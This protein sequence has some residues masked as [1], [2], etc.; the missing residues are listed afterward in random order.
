M[1]M[2]G[3]CLGGALAG[4][5]P[6]LTGSSAARRFPRNS[7]SSRASDARMPTTMAAGRAGADEET[8]CDAVVVGTSLIAMFEALSLAR[9]GK[10]VRM[11]EKEGVPGGAWRVRETTHCLDLNNGSHLFRNLK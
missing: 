10:R 4:L 6:A 3:A 7:T 5:G 8:P 1:G 2:V 11:V 9:S